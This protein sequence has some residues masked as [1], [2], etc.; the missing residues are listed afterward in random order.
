M[1][2]VLDNAEEEKEACVG[3]DDDDDECERKGRAERLFYA[4]SCDA[5]CVVRVAGLG[6]DLGLFVLP[7]RVSE[8]VRH[9]G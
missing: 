7:R 4:H 1:A 3:D 5:R 8:T 9:R 2:L 6:E